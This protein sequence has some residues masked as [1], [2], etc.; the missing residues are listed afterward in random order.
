MATKN[1]V[2]RA[3]GEGQIGTS[4]KSWNIGYFV[5][6]F[7]NGVTFNPF[8][9]R[10]S[11]DLTTTNTTATDV[12]GFGFNIAAN[13]VWSFEIYCKIGSS[14]AA[15]TKYAINIP[16]GATIMAQ[17]WGSLGST[18]AY[19]QDTIS[20]ATTLG[21]AFNTAGLTTAAQGANLTI[22]GVVANGSTP[23]TVQF[24]HAKGTSGTSTIYANSY[25][26]ARRIS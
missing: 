24:Q 8:N 9:F 19:T 21:V 7:I 3:N 15:G 13:E 18:T 6:L 23:G 2:P 16:S 11:G 20:A 25:M 1:I 12:T 22:R 14:S 17:V 26:V 5:S 10:N 4:S